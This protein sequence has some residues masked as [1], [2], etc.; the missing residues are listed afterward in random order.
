MHLTR[1]NKRGHE[2]EYMSTYTEVYLNGKRT[3]PLQGCC[4]SNGCF[5]LFPLHLPG[6]HS[7]RRSNI[8]K[9][10]AIWL[11][12]STSI[13]RQHTA[14]SLGHPGHWAPSRPKR[15]LV[16]PRLLDV[17]RA[18]HPTSLGIWLRDISA[19]KQPRRQ[20]E[21]NQD[22]AQPHECKSER[23]DAQSWLWKA[24]AK[25]QRVVDSDNSS[26]ALPEGITHSLS[27]NGKSHLTHQ[28]THNSREDG[29]HHVELHLC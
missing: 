22:P 19:G 25:C 18:E 29:K 16:I 21:S 6:P 14:S 7:I 13:A 2:L 24:R 9:H 10:E 28:G 3:A 26:R 20:E 11:H 5:H 8:L 15:R 27:H 1:P 17:V 4:L 23:R 12:F